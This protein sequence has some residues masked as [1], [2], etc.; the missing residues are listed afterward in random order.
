[1]HLDLKPDNILID[2]AKKEVKVIDWGISEYFHMDKDYPL[3]VV[4][5]FYKAPELLVN[6]KEYDYSVDIF[7][8]GNVFAKM[9]FKKGI[10]FKGK[11]EIDQLRLLSKVLGSKGLKD[12]HTKYKPK[13]K[14]S[15][16]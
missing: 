15:T 3:K 16:E 8:L 7:S 5:L 12:Y 1:M 13:K 6:I 14:L 10:F 4:T 11:N 2:K 9:I